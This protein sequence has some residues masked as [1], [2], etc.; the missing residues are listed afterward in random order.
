MHHA[1]V[2]QVDHNVPLASSLFHPRKHGTRMKIKGSSD[3]KPF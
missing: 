3:F 2:L 1:L